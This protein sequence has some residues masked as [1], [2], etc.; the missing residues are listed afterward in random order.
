[1]HAGRGSVALHSASQGSGA[2]RWP[3][4]GRVP[5][6]SGK[7][8]RCGKVPSSPVCTDTPG[9]PAW[10]QPH[11]VSQAP[12]PRAGGTAGP[13]STLI[14]WVPHTPFSKVPT[15]QCPVN[16]RLVVGT[17]CSRSLPQRG[18]PKSTPDPCE[19]YSVVILDEKRNV[20]HRI[21]DDMPPGGRD[22]QHTASRPTE[23]SYDWFF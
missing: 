3:G 10:A 14:L 8:A 6:G 17:E 19:T 13:E 7:L 9:T 20:Y 15:S 16:S 4:L 18:L 1:M 2:A 23:M 12:S 21:M 5:S 22:R 11:L